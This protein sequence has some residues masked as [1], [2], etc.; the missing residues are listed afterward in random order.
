MDCVGKPSSSNQT[1]CQR[2]LVRL[3]CHLGHRH[4]PLGNMVDKMHRSGR[5]LRHRNFHHLG[6]KGLTSHH[7]RHPSRCYSQDR[8]RQYLNR[9][10]SDHR[11]DKVLR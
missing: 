4:H 11:L 6:H 3:N 2:S 7:Y 9:Y 5:N 10:R 1:S 8:R